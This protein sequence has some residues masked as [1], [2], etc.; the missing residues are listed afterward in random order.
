[1]YDVGCKMAD[2]EFKIRPGLTEIGGWGL[3]RLKHLEVVWFFSGAFCGFWAHFCYFSWFALRKI[4][5]SK[6]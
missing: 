4:D 3:Q 2:V 6:R 5:V 1:M